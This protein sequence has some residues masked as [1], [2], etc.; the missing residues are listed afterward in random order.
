[1]VLTG[2]FNAGKNFDNRIIDVWMVGFPVTY[3]LKASNKSKDHGT[4]LRCIPGAG[5]NI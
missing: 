4:E 2:E 3:A 1:M 5:L